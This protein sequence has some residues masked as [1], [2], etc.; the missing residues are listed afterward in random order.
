MLAASSDARF[1]GATRKDICSIEF[2][3]FGSKR[4][5]SGTARMKNVLMA[6]VRLSPI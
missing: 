3:S 1:R 4:K 2:F 5:L 6:T